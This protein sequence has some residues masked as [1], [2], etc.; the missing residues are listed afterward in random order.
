MKIQFPVRTIIGFHAALLFALSIPV[1]ATP[2][3]YG[4]NSGDESSEES[5]I[6]KAVKFNL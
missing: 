1:L 4:N 6:K 3:Q 5:S 2:G